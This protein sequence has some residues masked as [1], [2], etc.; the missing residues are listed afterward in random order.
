MGLKRDSAAPVAAS[1]AERPASIRWL[2]KSTIRMPFLAAK[3]IKVTKPTW[4]YTLFT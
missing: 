2:A 3:P 4:A 1:M